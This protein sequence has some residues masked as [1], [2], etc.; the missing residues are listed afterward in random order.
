M[1]VEKVR[2]GS[3]ANRSYLNFQF[4]RAPFPTQMG[5]EMRGGLATSTLFVPSDNGDDIPLL[6][7]QKSRDPQLLII[8]NYFRLTFYKKTIKGAKTGGLVAM[9]LP[10][11]IHL[12]PPGYTL[13]QPPSTAGQYNT[14]GVRRG[15]EGRW[16]D[17]VVHG[18]NA[19]YNPLFFKHN[20]LKTKV[21]NFFFFCFQVS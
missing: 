15:Q 5:G 2:Y 6:R 8:L 18:H 4:N 17:E 16:K 1:S 19:N 20:F 12:L 10:L 7:V 13:F 14:D 21:H 3:G 9:S 11:F